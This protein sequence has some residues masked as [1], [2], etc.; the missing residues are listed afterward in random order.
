MFDYY[1]AFW[2]QF[3][4]L[5]GLAII[6]ALSGSGPLPSIPIRYATTEMILLQHNSDCVTLLINSFNGSSS[7]W[8]KPSF[9]PISQGPLVLSL[10]AFPALPSPVSQ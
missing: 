8:I 5:Q 7:Y 3:L 9:F 2:Y 6:D 4:E 1:A 10:P